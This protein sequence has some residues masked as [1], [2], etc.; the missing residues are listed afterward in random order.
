MSMAGC[1]YVSVCECAHH[2][3]DECS[4]SGGNFI[5]QFMGTILHSFLL[6]YGGDTVECIESDVDRRILNA[7]LLSISCYDFGDLV[8]T[9]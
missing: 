1:W 5:V 8:K 6:R 3:G 2:A 4:G 9:F 7:V